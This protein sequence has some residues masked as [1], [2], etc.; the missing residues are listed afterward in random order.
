MKG[1]GGNI[2]S[3]SRYI[4]YIAILL[5]ILTFSFIP[6]TSGDNFHYFFMSKSILQGHYSELWTPGNPL[7]GHFVPGLP[8]LLLPATI[9]G[10]ME[11]SKFIILIS[12]VLLLFGYMRFVGDEKKPIAFGALIIL[13]FSPALR[14]FSSHILSEIPYTALL[15]FT[16]LILKD[17]KYIVA[18]I[19]SVLAFYVRSVGIALFITVAVVYFLEERKWK[20]SCVA[21][22]MIS[23]W[24]IYTSF[25]DVA[26][27]YSFLKVSLQVSPY[28]EVIRY[29]TPLEFFQRIL[30]NIKA[31]PV[32]VFP[33]LFGGV[34]IEYLFLGFMFVGVWKNRH[35]TLELYAGLHILTLLSW[36]AGGDYRYY[37]PLLPIFSLWI[38]EGLYD[39]SRQIVKGNLMRNCV[40]GLFV[41]E[42]IAYAITFAPRIYKDNIAWTMDGTVS[43]SPK[44]VFF[45]AY[46]EA[47][48]KLR[49]DN[50][51]KDVT[52]KTRKPAIFYYFTGYKSERGRAK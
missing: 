12:F 25:W 23:L 13:A 33:K 34:F 46:M 29:L 48:E 44:Y 32:L 36:P 41:L 45:N 18:L 35:R 28:S 19:L 2:N 10:H 31:I 11:A 3:K 20:W 49:N 5:A 51:P 1:K 30:L 21:L 4:I 27:S 42:N 39:I 52:F 24:F 17:R 9:F 47:D 16:F 6:V 38:A 50:I 7:H 22:A 40:L 26:G 43:N 8:V 37:I 14:L 15:V